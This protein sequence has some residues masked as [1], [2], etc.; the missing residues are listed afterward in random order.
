MRKV[1]TLSLKERFTLSLFHSFS[2]HLKPRMVT[3]S[4]ALHLKSL[5]TLASTSEAA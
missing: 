3:H 2:L 5:M 4:L 1:H